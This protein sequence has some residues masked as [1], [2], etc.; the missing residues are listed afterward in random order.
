[1]VRWR[2]NTLLQICSF[3]PHFICY[4][5]PCDFSFLAFLHLAAGLRS[6]HFCVFAQL[7]LRVS[8][9]IIIHQRA[10][11]HTRTNTTCHSSTPLRQAATDRNL[12]CLRCVCESRPTST[13][14]LAHIFQ[15]CTP[16]SFTLLDSYLCAWTYKYLHA[17]QEIWWGMLATH[18]VQ[19]W[20]GADEWSR[21]WNR[22]QHSAVSD[23]TPRGTLSC[24]EQKH[25]QWQSVLL[26][27]PWHKTQTHAHTNSCTSAIR[28]LEGHRLPSKC[29]KSL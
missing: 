14:V 10:H 7:H 17:L 22:G 12:K 25:L 26:T 18:T 3:H 27:V 15:A 24:A 9:G 1:M 20:R 16:V 8:E 4:I 11:T 21:V 28:E 29:C 6:S 5:I 13:D 2:T 19:E 23:V